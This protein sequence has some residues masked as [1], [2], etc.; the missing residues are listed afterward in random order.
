MVSAAAVVILTCAYAVALAI[1]LLSLKPS[2]EPI[3]DPAFAIKEC[4]IIVLAPAMVALMA[5]R[6]AGDVID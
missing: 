6:R 5:I 4:L 1:G 3:G 2:Q